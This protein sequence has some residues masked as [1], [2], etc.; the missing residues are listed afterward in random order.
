M[1]RRVVGRQEGASRTWLN[2]SS[3]SKW[4]WRAARASGGKSPCTARYG[5][6]WWHEITVE[7]VD[8]PVTE[9]KY[10]RVVEKHGK[11]PPQY[12]DLEDEEE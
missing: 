12:P 4:P 5:D 6:E 9:G 2:R 3:S 10:P 11:S 8:A 7:D 1:D